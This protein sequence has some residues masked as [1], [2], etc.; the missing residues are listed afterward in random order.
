MIL[1]H[2]I[3]VD[4]E[5]LALGLLV[6]SI[7]E[8]C[9]SAQISDFRSGHE[10]LQF[11]ESHHC[12]VAFLDIHMRGIDG[13]TLAKKIRELNP[14]CNL[15]FVTGYSEYAGDA[16]SMHASG[17]IIKPVSA[18]AVHAELTD[19]RHPVALLPNAILRIRCFGNFEVFSANGE[20]IK[21]SRTKAKE[22]FAYLVYRRGSS[23]STRELAAVLFEDSE[24]STKQMLYLQ[25]IISS[26][27]QTLR[28]HNAASVIHKTYNAIA[29]HDEGVDCDYYRFLKMDVPSINTYTGE[30]MTQYSW[31]E[32]V[33]GYLDR[34]TTSSAPAP[35]S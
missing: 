31:A 29:L 25:K 33:A 34:I 28:E 21:F 14:Q 10:A 2:I 16:L 1:L 26:M 23:C 22:L 32:F 13:L 11:L 9:P 20:P 6:R 15:I 4:D 27:M 18:E 3:A 19:L 30:F 17:Y 7:Q 12:D 8:A 24:Y 35:D 5:P